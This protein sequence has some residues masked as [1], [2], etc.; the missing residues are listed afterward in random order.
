MKAFSFF[1]LFAALILFS[2]KNE[3]AETSTAV[4]SDSLHNENHDTHYSEMEDSI[5]FHI[6]NHAFEISASD[7]HA[8]GAVPDPFNMKDTSEA[9]RI[10]KV[11]SA[12]SRSGDSLIFQCANN[13]KAYIINSNNEEDIDNYSVYSFIQDMPS[14]N[15][16][17]LMASYYEAY[18]YVFIDKTSGDTTLLYGMPV[19]SPDNKYILTFNQDIEAGFTFN[20]LQLLEIKDSKPVIIGEKPLYSWGPDN[21]KWKDATTLLVQQSQI[22]PDSTNGGQQM[23]TEY[24]QIKMK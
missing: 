20:G 13:Q 5:I 11:A 3:N 1:T 21:V 8:F 7:E 17:L 4:V 22:K 16:W 10:R 12:V 15:Q 23:V 24:V 6:G 18:G 9:S 19:V 14:I 2:C